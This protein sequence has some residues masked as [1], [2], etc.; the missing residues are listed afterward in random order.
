MVIGADGVNMSGYP[1]LLRPGERGMWG[2]LKRGSETSVWGP[3]GG[4]GKWEVSGETER[5]GHQNG[6]YWQM[7][8]RKSYLR[9]I[10]LQPE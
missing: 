3:K 9:E 2:L 10:N 5:V 6:H 7:L 4:K 8:R 1:I